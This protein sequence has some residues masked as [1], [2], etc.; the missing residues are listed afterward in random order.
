MGVFLEVNH[1]IAFAQMRR[2]V[3]QRQLSILFLTPM[4]TEDFCDGQEIKYE[5]TG[6]CL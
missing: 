6:G 1:A 3:Y 5:V 4:N 2:A